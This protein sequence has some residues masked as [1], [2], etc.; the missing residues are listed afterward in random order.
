MWRNIIINNTNIETATNKAILI[1]MP[2]NSKYK[3]Y[4]FWHPA[5]LVRTV[6]DK[7]N[8]SLS[9]TEEF[10]FKL[11][12]YGNG[13]YN[14]YDVINEKEIDYT[15]LEEAFDTI[16]SNLTQPKLDKYETYKP[17]ELEIEEVKVIDELME[18]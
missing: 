3:G 11:F 2:N 17:K 7:K 8:L 12:K 4:M 5:K 16:N 15:E 10:S 13:K 6:K 18:E 1:K 9:Y 14:K